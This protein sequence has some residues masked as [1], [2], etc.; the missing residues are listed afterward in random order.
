[1]IH[2]EVVEKDELKENKASL[3]YTYNINSKPI[4]PLK[5]LSKS[6]WMKWLTELNFNPIPNSFTYG[7]VLDR[8]FGE[9]SYRF[10]DEIYKTWFDKR[11]TWDRNYTLR[12]PQN[13]LTQFQCCQLRCH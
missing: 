12:G 4:Q 5:G 3:D 2:N 13:R 8:R 10:S 1:V 6:I 11:F 7:M 9:R